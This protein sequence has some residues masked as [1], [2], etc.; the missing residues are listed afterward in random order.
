VKGQI[1][2]VFRKVLKQDPELLGQEFTQLL[3]EEK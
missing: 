1:A 3:I 2:D